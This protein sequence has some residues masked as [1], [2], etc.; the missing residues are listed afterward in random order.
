MTDF[1]F[2]LVTI[3]AGSGGVAASRR[4]AAYGAKAAIV[5]GRRVAGTC[6]LRGC[7]PKKLLIY[8]V[9][10]ADE[11]EDAAGYGWTIGASSLDWARLIAAKDREIDRLHGI[12]VKL[13]Q[14]SGVQ[15]FDG[16]AQIVGPNEVRVGDRTLRTKHILIA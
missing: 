5:E 3:G 12:Y 15:I 10:F 16:W 11:I 2:D 8:G 9:H 1:D 7:V 14:D 6:V 4:A 13:L